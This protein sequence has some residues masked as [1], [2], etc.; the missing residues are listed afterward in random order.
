M[1]VVAYG[2]ELRRIRLEKGLERPDLEER[3]GVHRS[4]I[5]RIELGQPTLRLGTAHKIA[6]ALGVPHGA[7]TGAEVLNGAEL[8]AS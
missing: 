8:T 7:F 3:S 5:T 2:K 4:T 1:N 6:E